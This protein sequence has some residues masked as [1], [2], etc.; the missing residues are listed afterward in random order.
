MPHLKNQTLLFASE[1]TLTFLNCEM[2]S[3]DVRRLLERYSV[4]ICWYCVGTIS[5]IVTS[6]STALSLF[7]SAKN[8][9]A[10][11]TELNFVVTG[12]ADG[13]ENVPVLEELN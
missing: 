12:V 10:T 9:V 11:K 7:V 6:F 5:M 3:T 2:F 13:F 4:S 8:E 1:M